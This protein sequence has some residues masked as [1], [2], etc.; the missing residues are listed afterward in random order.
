MSHLPY[1]RCAP[2]AT[3]QEIADNWNLSHHS[4]PEWH[5]L[6]KD[7]QRMII[8]ATR[9]PYANGSIPP[10]LRSEQ[11]ARRQLSQIAEKEQLLRQLRVKL[12]A[13]GLPQPYDERKTRY[14]RELQAEIDALQAMLPPP[15]RSE[16]TEHRQ[17]SLIVDHDPLYSAAAI[18]ARRLEREALKLDEPRRQREAEER[19]VEAERIRLERE[20]ARWEEER[21]LREKQTAQLAY[22]VGLRRARKSQVLHCCADSDPTWDRNHCGREEDYGSVN[23]SI[24][25]RDAWLDILTAVFQVDVRA[26]LDEIDITWCSIDEALEGLSMRQIKML[27][28]RYHEGLSPPMVGRIVGHAGGSDTPVGRQTVHR[29]LSLA[30]QKLRRTLL[31]HVVA[32]WNLK[33]YINEAS[34]HPA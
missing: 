10:P 31:A 21:P 7:E 20:R 22:Q 28:T 18:E 5:A 32:P 24:L 27:R 16:Q 13:S 4:L 30:M 25:S 34:D 23:A 2:D 11:T 14:H 8:H 12:Q 26:H 17:L 6:G 33:R 9:H 3:I 19:R 1:A 29:V 15:L